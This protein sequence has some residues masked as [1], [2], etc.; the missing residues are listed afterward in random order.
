MVLDSTCFATGKHLKYI[1]AV[2]NSKIGYYLLQNSPKTGT[3]D[4]L[5]SVQAIEPLQIP[6]ISDSDKCK[7]INLVDILLSL[8]DIHSIAEI[9]NEI[10]LMIYKFYNFSVEEI[11]FIKSLF[12]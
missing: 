5:I 2:L 10:E 3:G 4:L 6:N 12:Q 11:T 7:I 8:K 1:L 9:E